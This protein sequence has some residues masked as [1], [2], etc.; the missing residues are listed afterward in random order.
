MSRVQRLEGLGRVRPPLT[1]RRH[2]YLKRLMDERAEGQCLPL[3]PWLEALDVLPPP[4][5]PT[6]EVAPAL[7][8]A[9]ERELLGRAPCAVFAVRWH[10]TRFCPL[11]VRFLSVARE[12]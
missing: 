9:Q 10:Y 3:I 8:G 5:L 11:A 7:A 12:G 6:A 1:A 2:V 4:S